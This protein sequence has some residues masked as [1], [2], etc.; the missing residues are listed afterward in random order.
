MK[1]LLLLLLLLLPL[2]LSAQ[3]AY[4]NWTNVHQVIDGFGGIDR[5]DLTSAQQNFVF[6]TG[7]GQLGISILH[8]NVQDGSS[9]SCTSI[10][11]GCITASTNMQA[12]IANGGRVW[13][14]GTQP[15]SA[16]L[17]TN[18]FPPQCTYT[19]ANPSTQLISGDYGAFAT[20]MANY[21]VSLKNQGVPIYGISVQNEPDTC[22]FTY[23][24][25]A[26]IDTF[27]RANLGPTLASAG[28]STPVY[29][30]ETATYADIPTWGS[31]CAGDTNCTQYFGGVA[32]HDYQL[33]I[34]SGFAVTSASY[35]FSGRGSAK[36]WETEFGMNGCMGPNSWDPQ[37]CEPG[38]NTDMAV[39]GLQWA[40]ILDQRMAVDGLNAWMIY[41]LQTYG[42]S[43]SPSPCDDGLING[44]TG[45]IAQRAYVMGQYS[46][47]V[48]PGYY[49]IDA[50]H[51][52][53]SGVTISAYQ[54][55]V[56]GNLAIIATNYTGSSVSQTFTIQNAPTFTTLTPTITSASQSLTTLSNV[57]VSSQSFTY[58]LPAQSIITFAGT[59]SGSTTYSLTATATNGSISGTNCAS[60]TYTPST[61][62]GPCTATPSSGYSFTG[63]SGAGACSGATGTG[64]ASCTMTSNATLTAT[65]TP[66]GGTIAAASCSQA[67]VQTALNSVTSSTAF[68]TIPS[69]TCAWTGQLNF[70]IPSG[71][72]NLT[73]QGNTGVACTG[74]P[75]QS[76][77]VCTATDSTI[78][79]D[80]YN[81]SNSTWVISNANSAS[82][83]GLFRMTGLTIEGGSGGAAHDNG[84]IQIN[85][86][87]NNLRIDHIDFNM[88][89]YSPIISPLPVRTL[90]QVQ[91]VADHNIQLAT[92]AQITS[93]INIWAPTSPDT[94]G[95]GDGPWAAP[96]GLGGS[97]FF[98]I[99][100]NYM[101][102]GYLEDCGNG[103]GFVA[104]YNTIINGGPISAVIHSH[105]TYSE[106]GRGRSCRAYEAYN[107]YIKGPTSVN[108]DAVF[109]S[110]GGPSM[111]WGNTLAS[112]YNWF[113][114]VGSSRNDGSHA[115]T[116]T[117]NGWGYCG[118]S[119][120]NPNT[121][122]A[123]GVGSAW[124]GNSPSTTGW[125]CLDG[126]G[127][128][129]GAA[130]NGQYFP[131]AGL[132]SSGSPGWPA[133][134][135]EPI[136]Y[137]DNTIQNG[138]SYIRIGSIS[139]Q[140]NRDVFY[141]CD[142]LNSSCSGGFT[143]VYGTGSGLLSARPSTCAAGPGGTYG[144]S[145]TGSY[146][147]AYWATDQQ[148]LYVCTATN[149]W[150]GIYTPY[151]YPHPLQ[152][153]SSGV[154]LTISTTGTGTG[155]V[156]GT[157]C[158]TS[159]YVSGTSVACTAT[160]TG[161]STL[162]SLVGTG[163]ISCTGSTCASGG[164]GLTVPSTV[165]ATFTGGSSGVSLTVSSTG[166]GTGTLTGSNCATG[167][168]SSS[169]A[170]SCTATPTGGS[171]LGSLVGTGN[172]SCSGSSCSGTLTTTSTVTATFNT[173][174][175]YLLTV[176]ASNGFVTGT[177]CATGSYLSGTL[178]GPC[179]PTP[180]SGYSFSGWSALTG[181]ATCSG[182]V[183]PCPQFPLGQASG[184]T[185]N[186]VPSAPVPPINLSGQL[187]TKQVVIK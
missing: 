86:P 116:N 129:Q 43:C 139:D 186:F 16:Y 89:T 117:P 96:T 58:T 30:P 74:T 92:S 114:A 2:S 57:S 36:Y 160:A 136:Y 184:F 41:L 128:G 78:I 141:D 22:G 45:S 178:I 93:M 138:A 174:T 49:R 98:F 100:D 119:S 104:R 151:I 180:N 24:S 6:G 27:V 7:G 135:L 144:T 127:R 23:Y 88:T 166:S 38:W 105:G 159:S 110:T 172:M 37:Y 54:N 181:S 137:F 109:G 94:I 103:G 126:L 145:P 90:G 106:N 149:T 69:G 169:T 143:G 132:A 148:Q 179:T 65:F 20:W 64:T 33:N 130:L 134:K 67:N 120:I 31:T 113:A 61:S 97:G 153:G 102:G 95:Y 182:S 66:N 75:G 25:A 71:N 52:P 177:N 70:T 59:G 122:L 152:G 79:Q 19:G 168:Y 34:T 11:T 158:A 26:N 83:C 14:D 147:V 87:C 84:I 131:S 50:T 40:A 111:V 73:I 107:N 118:T 35:P 15:P 85:G 80:A 42:T 29:M 187:I 63:W 175:T 82:A 77:Y 28:V 185:A 55:T 51:A 46:K 176:T 62:I 4:V 21:V 3:T 112:G 142:S 140:F 56:G 13:V 161:G 165:T 156:S 123:N 53:Q 162:A 157:N 44:N 91:G 60:G 76:N 125:P 121:G 18:I 146:G 101:N 167:S 8:T 170:V 9:G 17:N 99:E 183:V 12:V 115:E 10:G 81:S 5:D 108:D 154:S 68:V 124:D 72:T 133:E 48:R 1:K 32:Y 47:F 150:T 155:T 163:S 173:G 171:T 39:D 164:G